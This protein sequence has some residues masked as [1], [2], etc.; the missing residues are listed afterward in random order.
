MKCEPFNIAGKLLG[1]TCKYK[2][3]QVT[4][5]TRELAISLCLEIECIRGVSYT[6][7]GNLDK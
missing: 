1:Y 3:T 7:L 6:Q 4:S 2:D 5:F